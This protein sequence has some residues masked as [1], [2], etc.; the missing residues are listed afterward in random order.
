[1]PR[2]DENLAAVINAAGYTL[3]LGCGGIGSSGRYME[4][5]SGG[6]LYVVSR[7]DGTFV[8]DVK[9]EFKQLGVNK[10]EGDDSDFSG[11]PAIS[12]NS[13]FIRSGKYLYCVA[14]EE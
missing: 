4:V 6:K 5:L 3:S 2:G 11:T 1:M 14:N 12:G 10:F 8:F 7:W 13:I 9:P